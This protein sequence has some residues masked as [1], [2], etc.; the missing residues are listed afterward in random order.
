MDENQIKDKERDKTI[1]EMAK[2]ICHARFCGVNCRTFCTYV[3]GRIPENCEFRMLVTQFVDAGYGKIE[4]AIQQYKNKLKENLF[5]VH[6][7]EFGTMYVVSEEAID[8]VPEIF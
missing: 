2:L 5:E 4:D 6:T 1:E 3:N 8:E 7:K